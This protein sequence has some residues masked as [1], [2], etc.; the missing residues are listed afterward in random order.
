[1]PCKQYMYSTCKA[2]PKRTCMH[3]YNDGSDNLIGTVS[4]KRVRGLTHYNTHTSVVAATTVTVPTTDQ[5]L[6]EIPALT[7]GR[8]S[9][10]VI[11]VSMAPTTSLLHALVDVT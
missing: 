10:H 6:T 4:S 3:T 7:G 1:M 8:E 5:D 11:D 9:L 2:Q